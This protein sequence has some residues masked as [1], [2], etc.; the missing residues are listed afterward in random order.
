MSNFSQYRLSFKQKRAIAAVIEANSTDGCTEH[1]DAE[2]HALVNNAVDFEATASAV[3]RIRR[4]LKIKSGG[5]S[6]GILVQRMLEF[7]AQINVMG[8]SFELLSK[9]LTDLENYVN[10]MDKSTGNI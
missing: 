10:P 4:E 2:L 6:N 1:T 7:E 5:L 9:R 8:K 3:S